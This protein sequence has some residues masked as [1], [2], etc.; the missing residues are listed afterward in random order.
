MA[1]IQLPPTMSSDTSPA[2]YVVTY[3]YC[4]PSFPGY[5]AFEAGAYTYW[6]TNRSGLH[7]I[8]L[9]MCRSFTVSAYHIYAMKNDNSPTMWW[10]LY[11]SL[12]NAN[13]TSL[14]TYTIPAGF[15]AELE[16]TFS[17]TPGTYRFLRL[18]I[19]ASAA[20]NG[21]YTTRVIDL[22]FTCDVPDMHTSPNSEYYVSQTTGSDTNDGLT[23]QTA[24]AT[25]GKAV[26]V[27]QSTDNDPVTVRVAPGIYRES[28]YVNRLDAST[29]KRTRFIGDPDCIF[30]DS[31]GP[32]VVRISGYTQNEQTPLGEFYGTDSYIVFSYDIGYLENIELCSPYSGTYGCSLNA[33]KLWTA[34]IGVSNFTKAE[35][36][37]VYSGSTSFVG[38]STAASSAYNCISFSASNGFST[39]TCYHC[40]SI[41]NN[42]GFNSC[43]SYNCAATLGLT[44]FNAGSC[45]NCAA[46]MCDNGFVSTAGSN[47]KT[48]NCNANLGDATGEPFC[49]VPKIQVLK[50]D[51]LLGDS[52]LNIVPI[53]NCY[54]SLDDDNYY[55]SPPSVKISREGQISFEFKVNANQ[56]T[57]RQIYVKH[58]NTAED[59]KPQVIIRGLGIEMIKTVTASSDTWQGLIFTFVP[60][61][62]GVM[63][64]ILCTRDQNENAYSLFSDP[65]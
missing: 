12:D 14:H 61:I 62:D 25:I 44:G 7:W 20:S 54:C 63:E 56:Y 55:I 48:Y 17:I 64:I 19:Q 37:E 65:A 2:P 23:A 36:C 57:A 60:P 21:A 28:L 34:L 49:F 46:S 16:A 8:K 52:T 26:N 50:P 3:D 1:T 42:I 15:S 5:L 27:L 9:D 10:T 41:A 47:R 39:A 31:C 53:E 18:D 51:G 58:L 40:F 38:I 59:L 6:M 30:F 24:F 4:H 11:G 13:W 32:G 22:D 43:T 33:C 29:N 35:K 45:Y